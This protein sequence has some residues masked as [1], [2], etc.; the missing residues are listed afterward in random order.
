MGCQGFQL[1]FLQHIRTTIQ[2]T[3]QLVDIKVVGL[4][5]VLRL[6]VPTQQGAGLQR[7]LAPLPQIHRI[8]EPTHPGLGEPFIDHLEYDI[9]EVPARCLAGRIGQRVAMQLIARIEEQGIELAMI[10][11]HKAFETDGALVHGLELFNGDG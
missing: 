8:G 11:M 6:R 9:A 5:P 7:N 2:A 10:V 4:V 1:A 3:L